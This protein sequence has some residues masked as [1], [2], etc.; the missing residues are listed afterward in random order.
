MSFFIQLIVNILIAGLPLLWAHVF[1]VE[2]LLIGLPVVV[3]ILS[4]IYNSGAISFKRTSTKAFPNILFSMFSLFFS[5]SLIRRFGPG[6]HDQEGLGWI[7][8]CFLAGTVITFLLFAT[9]Y[10]LKSNK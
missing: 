8:V 7:F 1:P 10:F 3:P 4:T 6:D 2:G 5:A 9:I